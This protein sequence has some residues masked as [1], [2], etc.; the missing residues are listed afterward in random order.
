MLM[1]KHTYRSTSSTICSFQTL[2]F[3]QNSIFYQST[4]AAPIKHENKKQE[5]KKQEKKKQEIRQEYP[6]LDT[7]FNQYQIAYRYRNS[8]ELLRGYLVYQLFSINFLTNNQEKITHWCRRILGDR[9]FKVLL[10]LTAFG[11][12]VGG[13]TPQEIQPIIKRLIDHNVSPILDYSVESDDHGQL[14]SSDQ[15]DHMHDHNTN[16][17]IECIQTSHDVCGPN[18]LIAIKVTALIRPTVLKKFNTILKSIKDRSL[19]PPLF[20]LINQEQKNDKI[21]ALLQESINARIIKDQ[22]DMLSSVTFVSN[23]LTEIHNLLIRLN[24]IAQACVE[25]NIS[26]MVD[27]EQTYFQTAI[28]YLA[29]ELQRYYNKSGVPVI[30]GTYQC[31]LKDALNSLTHD[32][33]VAEKYNYI[34]AAKLVRGAYMEQENRLARENAYES[35]INPTFE[36]TSQMYHTCFDKV[37][38]NIVKREPKNVRVM[39][40]S[41]NEDTVRYAIQKMKE[42][43]IHHDSSIVSFASL[44]GM[45]DYITFTLANSGYQAY[46]Y[47]PY[48][49]IEAL[50]PYLFRRAQENRGIFEKADKDRRL[51]FEA[52][53]DRIFNSKN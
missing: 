53:K 24:K 9:L 21:V 14:S 25:N 32:L 50:Q 7:K 4:Y 3:I 6:L 27:A 5:N 22:N 34:F 42:Y 41:H 39:I 33:A 10:K 19:L 8:F 44:Y 49:P 30:Y 47:L 35:L 51:H 17:F 13:E 15:I 16:K 1:I 48:G 28:N 52:F 38:Q 11:H 45:S 18:N 12:F 26:I 20:E 37:L 31:Y 43:D 46:K 36:A 2:K 29:T 40:A 23:D